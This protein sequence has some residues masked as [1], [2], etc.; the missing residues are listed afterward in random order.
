MYGYKHQADFINPVI[1]GSILCCIVK[2]I[3]NNGIYGQMVH[4][5]LRFPWFRK[6]LYINGTWISGSFA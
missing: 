3:L 5:S 2:I 4:Q 6:A 1:K